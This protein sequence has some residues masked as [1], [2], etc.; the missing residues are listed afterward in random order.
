MVEARVAGGGGEAP[1]KRRLGFDSPSPGGDTDRRGS[2]TCRP[3][4]ARAPRRSDTRA[5]RAGGPRGRSPARRGPGAPPRGRRRR[6]ASVRTPRAPPRSPPAPAA[7][8][9]SFGTAASARAASMRIVRIG[10]RR[11]GATSAS[12]LRGLE[13]SRRLEGSGAHEGIGVCQRA[14]DR[15]AAPGECVPAEERRGRRPPDRR[16]RGVRRR[17]RRAPLRPRWTPLA[18][19]LDDLAVRR[20]LRRPISPPLRRRVGGPAGR[21][22]R[23]DTGCTRWECRSRPRGRGAARG[24]CDRD[25]CA[26]TM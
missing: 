7:A 17:A 1:A 10:S 9:H 11:R 8:S 25:A 15:V 13:S 16:P 12:A 20:L 2:R 5:R 18:A 23:D 14:G 24:S 22:G 3:A 6:R 4:R 19:G 26:T 21:C